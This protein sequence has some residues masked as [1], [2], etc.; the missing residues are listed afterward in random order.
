MNPRRGLTRVE[1]LVAVAAVIVFGALALALAVPRTT[2]G[3]ALRAEYGRVRSEMRTLGIALEKYRADHGAYPPSTLRVE[4][5][6]DAAS[7]AAHAGIVGRTFRRGTPTLSALTTPVA[8]LPSYPLDVHADTKGT[9]FRY[10]AD[11]N[12]WIL[13]SWG[14]DCDEATGGQ[15]MWDGGIESIYDSS[16]PI[17]LAPILAGVG[18]RGA[19]TYDPSNGVVSAGDI[20]RVAEPAPRKAG[21]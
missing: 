6:V 2:R 13:G 19:Y 20:W 4:D 17:P 10:Y 12:G 21:S 3:E 1:L 14:P 18:P 16:L 11:A 5:Q 9:T 7:H 8:Y 15:L